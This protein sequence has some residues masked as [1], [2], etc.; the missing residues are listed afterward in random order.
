MESVQ[1]WFLY[2]ASLLQGGWLSTGWC[3]GQQDVWTSDLLETLCTF[4][5]QRCCQRLLFPREKKREMWNHVTQMPWNISISLYWRWA[6][7]AQMWRLSQNISWPSELQ[8]VK[9]STVKCICKLS[10]GSFHS[11]QNLIPQAYCERMHLSN[12]FRIL[13]P[14]K[15]KAW[16]IYFSTSTDWCLYSH[17]FELCHSI[18]E[19][20][21]CNNKRIFIYFFLL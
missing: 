21:E 4:G 13:Y 6:Q 9:A 11:C 5:I 10:K 8:R 18:A 17:I 14:G 7:I 12:P 19:L 3:P 15:V 20:L 16:L 1:F 2:D